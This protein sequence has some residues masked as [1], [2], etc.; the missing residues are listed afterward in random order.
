[1][2]NFKNKLAQFMYG[3]YGTDQLYLALIALYFVLIVAN[4]FINSTIIRGIMFA[5][6]I[7][8]VFRALS[9][10]VYKRNMENEKFMK[11][12]KPIKSK[13]AFEIRRIK[14]IKT[15]RFRKC[16]HC[17]KM[18]RLKRLRGKHTVKCPSCNKEFELRI[19]G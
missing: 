16:P 5:I 13:G 14:E 11:F 7:W 12:F 1:M 17:K 19:L 15:H 6:L 9:R 2:G 8:I 3:R 18:L 10:N 4:A